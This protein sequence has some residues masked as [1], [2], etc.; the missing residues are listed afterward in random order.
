M[1]LRPNPAYRPR[2]PWDLRGRSVWVW[3]VVIVAILAWNLLSTRW[4]SAAVV[5]ALWTVAEL[6]L[7]RQRNR[8][9]PGEGAS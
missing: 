7:R 6:L 3:R 8:P 2:E 5:V 9:R 4:A 1:E